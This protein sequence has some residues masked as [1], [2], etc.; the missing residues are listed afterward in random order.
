MSSFKQHNS[1]GTKC[2]NKRPVGETSNSNHHIK[3]Q[4]ILDIDPWH[5]HSCTQL[6]PFTVHTQTCTQVHIHIRHT[7]IGQQLLV[8]L[9]SWKQILQL[10]LLLFHM[11]QYSYDYVHTNY[12]FNIMTVM[13]QLS[14][15]FHL[16]QHFYNSFSL[17]IMC[18]RHADVAF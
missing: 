3:Q 12:C 11:I 5:P 6:C 15:L 1:L 17:Y 10:C 14:F 4:K 8:C 16:L 2:S 13:L 7:Y 9:Q 18:D